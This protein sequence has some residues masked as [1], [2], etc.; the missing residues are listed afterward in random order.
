MKNLELKALRAKRD[1]RQSDM[2]ELLK[3]S[4][5]SYCEKENGK[6]KFKLVEAL[7]IAETF[8]VNVRDIFLTI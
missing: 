5:S 8:K 4:K 7:I 3:I 2:A 6:R 1:L